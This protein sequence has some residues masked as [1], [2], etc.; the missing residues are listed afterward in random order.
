MNPTSDTLS[1]LFKNTP[2]GLH[3][4]LLSLTLT[5]QSDLSALQLIV[6]RPTI[7]TFDTFTPVIKLAKPVN[8]FPSQEAKLY[9]SFSSHVYVIPGKIG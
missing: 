4:I 6:P 1:Q 8:G 2:L 7:L 9:S 5:H 3:A